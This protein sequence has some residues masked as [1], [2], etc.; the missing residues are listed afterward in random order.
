MSRAARALRG[1]PLAACLAGAL[2]A[3]AARAGDAF[4]DVTRER[5]IGFVSSNGATGRKYLVETM[6]AGAA[7]LDH[8]GDGWLD[9][10][11]VQGHGHPEKALD[12]PGGPGEPGDVLYRNAAGKRFEDVTARAGV[13]DRGYG[14][15]AA[16]GDYDGDGR[17]DLYVTNYG[18]NTLYRNRGDGT[19][20]DATE[21]ARASG[22]GWSTSAT[23]VDL[24]SDG[25]LD[26]Y[27]ARYLE[28]DTR[29]HGACSTKAPG[30]AEKV[31]AYCHPHHFEGTP[32]L[33]YRN[34][35]DGAFEDVSRRSG[36]GK[37]GG[38]LEG[39]GLGVVA[40]DF[41]SDGD[42][43]VLVANDS[44][45]NHLWRNLGGFRFEDAALEA[46]F[47]LNA[48]GAAQ[49]GMGIDRGDVD[50][51]GV[52]DVY[53]TNF[54]RETDTLYVGTGASF[55]DLTVERGLALATYLPL[56]F[57]VRL[58]DFDLDGDLDLY[59][60]NGHIL[61]N[62]ERLHPG[63][64]ITSAQPDFL[65][66]NDG[67]GSFRDASRESG[68]WFARALVGRGVAEGDYDNDGD[69][70]L[71]VTNVAGPAVLLENRAGDGKSWIGLELRTGPGGGAWH[72]ALVEIEAAGR[73]VVRVAQTDGSYLSAHDPRVRL[74]L[75][76][77][78][79]P[80]TARVRWPGSTSPEAFAGLTPGRYHVLVKGSGAR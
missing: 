67:K 62:A 75:P 58:L 13:G 14:M 53:V 5:G 54:S 23:W 16:A 47:A 11:L 19:F 61:D 3:P 32:D 24:D 74:G 78:A 20:E 18:R 35:G 80:V 51:D 12:G 66:E 57:G 6:L 17:P 60:A 38:W 9:L 65:L 2:A 39:K 68:A 43:D 48:E 44:V 4:V 42:Q 37:A 28:Y 36:V 8:D 34:L 73:K 29:K 31:P 77:G 45:P 40:F 22:G 79:G 70:D 56:A 71:L 30:S 72:G 15:G 25:R 63:E 69:P 21:R 1:L 41:D 76:A 26:L 46:G 52:L 7:W 27:V 50:S 33:V 64:G 49:A 59:V 10:Y 55:L